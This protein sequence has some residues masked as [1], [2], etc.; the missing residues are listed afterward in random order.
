MALCPAYHSACYTDIQSG[1]MHRYTVRRTVYLVQTGCVSC[2][3]GGEFNDARYSSGVSG[4]LD[5]VSPDCDSV[6]GT[7]LV[8]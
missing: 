2:I 8:C 1:T 3:S 5:L 4:G 6:P 7:D